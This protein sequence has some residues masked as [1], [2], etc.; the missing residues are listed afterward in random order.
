MSLS[1]KFV[2]I[3][4]YIY[5]YIIYIYTHDIY[6]QIYTLMIYT[7]RIILLKL[8]VQKVI[9]KYVLRVVLNHNEIIMTFSISDLDG[10][11]AVL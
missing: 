5:I 1:R 4:I 7:L 2:Y 11:M 3:N 6:T 8:K 10:D 9:Y